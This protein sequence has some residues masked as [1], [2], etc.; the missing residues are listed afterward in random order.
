MLITIISFYFYKIYNLSKGIEFNK[1][2][3]SE[4]LIIS[5]NALSIISDISYFSKDAAGNHFEI[6]SSSGTTDLTNP[7]IINMNLVVAKIILLTSEIIYITSDKAKYNNET[8]ETNFYGNVKAI[9]L[10]HQISSDNLHLFFQNNSISMTNNV[11]Y[12]NPNAS[13]KADR[14]EIDIL[15]KKLNIFMNDKNKKVKALYSN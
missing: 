2:I 10:E 8:Y 9:Y 1:V 3:N 13:M 11:F 12:Q 7:N 5:E 6:T 15:V 4:K 14:I